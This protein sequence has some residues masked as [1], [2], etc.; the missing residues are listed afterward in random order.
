MVQT[1]IGIYV[2][3]Q[4]GADVDQSPEDVGIIV[5]GVQVLDEPKDVATACALLFGIIYDLNLSYP[6]DL[7]YTFEF[8]QKI[9]MEL[10]TQRLSNK[11]QVLKNKLLEWKSETWCCDLEAIQCAEMFL[12]CLPELQFWLSMSLFFLYFSLML[13]F[14]LRIEV[15]NWTLKQ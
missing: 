1:V 6:A 8:I 4:V 14:Y 13:L 3:K 7:R 5:E 15:S 12:S 11:I 9:L 10:D 2:I